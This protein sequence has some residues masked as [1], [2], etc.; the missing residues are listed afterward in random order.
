MLWTQVFVYRCLRR[1]NEDLKQASEVEYVARTMC[2]SE[3]C[4]RTPEIG[5][6]MNGY[7][8]PVCLYTDV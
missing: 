5:K 1:T 2:L 4:K 6:R 8:G 3:E 7:Q